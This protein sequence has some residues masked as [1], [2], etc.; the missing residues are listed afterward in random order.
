MEILLRKIPREI[1]YNVIIPYTYEIKSREHL[2]DIRNYCKLYK[3]LLYVTIYD[4]NEVIALNDLIRFCNNSIAPIYDIEPKY[5]EI[6]KRNLFFMTKTRLEIKQYIFYNFHRR[7][8]INPD[9]KIRILWGLLTNRE[10]KK[11]L[12]MYME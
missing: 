11:F 1:V 6:L 8:L 9:S 7:I 10:R 2:S 4:Y 12:T 3:K 5:E